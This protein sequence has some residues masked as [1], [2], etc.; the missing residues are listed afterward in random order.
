[1]DD[2]QSLDSTIQLLK[3]LI[4]EFDELFADMATLDG[5]LPFNGPVL[6]NIIEALKIGHWAEFYLDENKMHALSLAA[7]FDE[8]ALKHIVSDPDKA[9]E[10]I[11]VTYTA[12]L[13]DDIADPTKAVARELSSSASE[14]ELAT[15]KQDAL[16]FLTFLT[17]LHDCLACM[18]HG[19]SICKLVAAAQDGD[20]KAFCKAVQI[21]RTILYL[22]FAKKRMMLAQFD[23]DDQFLRSLGYRLKQP[24]MKGKIRYRT[25]YLAFSLL[26]REGFLALPHDQLLDVCQELG[27]YGKQHG[28]EDVGHLSKRLAEYRKKNRN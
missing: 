14:E 9:L 26:D 20:D 27:V 8:D 10:E 4:P 12:L 1:M 19:E 21:D 7:L 18:I 13:S 24:I 22:P 25:L 15:L 2:E 28:I 17:V 5:W 3:E 6:L 16:F 11:K 23:T